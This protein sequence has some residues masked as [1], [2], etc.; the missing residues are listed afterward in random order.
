[1]ITLR[2]FKP[3]RASL[4]D[5]ENLLNFQKNNGD[6]IQNVIAIYFNSMYVFK[7]EKTYFSL[8]I[9]KILLN[10]KGFTAF[11]RVYRKIMLLAKLLRP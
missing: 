10:P 1:M 2:Q 4:F 11:F 9:V 5:N 8:Y 3:I 6:D 7:D